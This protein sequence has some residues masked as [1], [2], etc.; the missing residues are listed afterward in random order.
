[1]RRALLISRNARRPTGSV[2]IVHA[3]AGRLHQAGWE[4]DV[5][6][7]QIRPQPWREVGARPIRIRTPPFLRGYGDRKTFAWFCELRRRRDQHEIVIG[8]GDSSHQ[9]V[10]FMHNL[11]HR[12]DEVIPGGTPGIV[13]TAGR[14]HKKILSRRRFRLLIANSR[15]MRDDLIARFDLPP[16]RVRVVYPGYDPQRFRPDP[17]GAERHALRAKLGLPEE[18]RLIGLVTSGDFRKRGLSLLFDAYAR[19]PVQLRAGTAL[20]IVGRDRMRPY[21]NQIEQLELQA[22]VRFVSPNPEVEKIY[23]ALDILVHP[24]H[25]EE[26]GLVVAEALASGLPVITSRQVGAA[27]LIN[28]DEMLL[29]Q[30]TVEGIASKL[31]H[32]LRDPAASRAWAVR[33]AQAIA[34]HTWEAYLDRVFAAMEEAELLALG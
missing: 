17:S 30:P 1:M 23:Q 9:D 34:G 26:F 28:D 10:L 21:L 3:L 7:Q 8:H 2:A 31:A 13:A 20:V 32:L 22:Q 24:A 11:V 27:E 15:L 29:A 33:G 19:L 5:Y 6:G 4:V 25:I 12:A 16:E 18:T 14:F